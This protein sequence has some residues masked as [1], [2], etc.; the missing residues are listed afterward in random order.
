MQILPYWKV[1]LEIIVLWYVIYMI[2]LFIKGTHTEQLLKG[3]VIIGI[4]FIATQQLR[5]DAIN[6][7]LERLVPISVIALLII[8][9]PELRRAL[10]RLGQ[11]GIHQE[12]IEV[13][14]EV[15]KVAAS[16]SKKK[17]GAL[18]AIER[19][20]GLKTYIE[21]GVPID[22]KVV[23]EVI[24]SI[25]MPQA[26]LHDGAIIIQNGRISAAGCLLPLTQ[27]DTAIPKSMGTRH[28]AAIGLTDETDAVCVIVSEETGAISIAVGGRLTSN[29]DE[30][31]L[32]KVLKDIFYKPIK[33]KIRFVEKAG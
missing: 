33:R 32:A 30:A 16:L 6:W 20:V 13:I 28:R 18:I 9:Q 10:A 24:A 29:L 12:D 7:V 2:L 5:L 14:E 21:S 25:F 31:G 11:F 23:P 19:E 3:L 17:I 22:C 26:P 1:I 4:I 27:E 15:S 8:F